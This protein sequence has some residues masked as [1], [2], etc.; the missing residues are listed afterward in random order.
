MSIDP[1][2]MAVLANRLD[3]IVREMEHTLLRTGRSGVLNMARD[4]SC[5]VTTGD[6]ELL[7]SAEGL[8][9]HIFGAHLMT[10][11]MTELHPDLA[12]GDA[13]LHNDPYLGNS[14]SADHTILVPV[15]H[16]GEH[17]FTTL[18]KAHQADIGNAEPT[19]YMPFAKD[20]YNEGA[21]I[22][23]CVRIQ[24]DRRDVDD[25]VRMCRARIRVADQWY[26]DYLAMV[27]AARIGEARLGELCDEY[28]NDTVQE[29]I[30]SWLDYSETQMDQAIRRMPKGTVTGR[31]DHDPI[32]DVLPDGVPIN[33]TVA[34]D[35]DAGRIGVDL[36]DNIDCVP[37]GVNESEACTISNVMA[38]I[39][40]SLEPGIPANSGAFRR[41]DL[42][43]RDGC[44]VGRPVFPR[45]TSVATTNVGDRLT[46]T[47]QKAIADAWDGFGAAEGA[48]G[49]GPGYAVVSGTDRRRGGAPYVNQYFLG[50][51]GGPAYPDIDGWV[52]YGLA[53]AAGLMFRDSVEISELKYPI[54]VGELRVRQDSEGAG[55]RRGAPGVTVR[56][57]PKWDPMT[58]S[59]VTDC[60]TFPPRG[61]QGGGSAARNIPFR[62]D[63]DGK[64]TEIAPL[65]AL[66]LSPGEEIGQHHTGGGGYGDPLAREPERVRDDVLAGFVSFPRARDVYGVVFTDEVTDATLT[67]DVA[68]TEIHRASLAVP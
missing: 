31:G 46:V 18:A 35:P 4:F 53:A 68:A 1:V 59:Y 30:A 57:G 21:L 58:A 22:F 2:L 13:F 54:R 3:S 42:S 11:A 34:V 26:G 7:S 40:N 63:P 38:G 56:Y 33:V 48:T 36:T 19:T 16:D 67:V 17:M 49:L 8:P 41:I 66:E 25:L 64:E 6:N 62:V 24:R 47:T 29:F 14:H 9:C 60:V 43:L 10:S 65:G 51:Q 52:T 15:L 61:T 28:G 44:I 20:V 27:G 50:S 32:G 37:A 23:P 45:S 55:R 12:D 5:A 39:F